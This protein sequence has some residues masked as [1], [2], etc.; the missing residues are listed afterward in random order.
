[1]AAECPAPSAPPSVPFP[2]L[3][4]LLQKF[5]K[6]AIP[7][8]AQRLDK[9]RLNVERLCRLC[10]WDR[11]H[12]EQVNARRTVQQL[13]MNVREVEKLRELV[14]PGDGLVFE[15]TVRP[16]RREARLTV[17]LLLGLGGGGA[18][19]FCGAGSGADGGGRQPPSAG[20]RMIT[21]CP[22]PSDFAGYTE[23]RSFSCSAAT[24][25]LGP[26][27]LPNEFK[28]NAV[29]LFESGLR[30]EGDAPRPPLPERP[31]GH[32][33]SESWTTLRLDLE[34][35]LEMLHDK[36]VR[37]PSGILR[38]GA[39]GGGGTEGTGRPGRSGEGDSVRDLAMVAAWPMAGALIGGVV[40][41]PLGFLTGLK[42]AAI[43][44][45]ISGS[46]IGFTGGTI[47]QKWKERRRERRR[48]EREKRD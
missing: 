30:E 36:E 29:S 19:G 33:A 25:Q 17:T 32:A 4:P 1:M 31:R 10:E 40:A 43:A 6:V 48:Q 28:E 23:R 20:E 22:S 44:A 12:Q 46:L 15:R 8:D 39:G 41:G 11:L 9:H 27:S 37:L 21:S 34:E 26:Q 45:V 2:R 47:I 38:R 18:P 24:E 14:V 7:T 42:V 13:L 3:E 35:L 5:V 16:A